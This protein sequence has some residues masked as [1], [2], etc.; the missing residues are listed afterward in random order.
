[1]SPPRTHRLLFIVGR[2]RRALYDSLRRTFENDDTVQIVLDR[3]VRE[4]RR[5]RPTRRTAERRRSERRAQRAID[6][7][8]GARGYAVVGVLTFLRAPAGTPAPAGRKAR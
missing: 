1:V 7:Q 5:R 3:R 8:L 6:A 4:R 2:Q